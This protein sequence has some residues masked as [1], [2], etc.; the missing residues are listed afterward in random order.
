MRMAGFVT[1]ENLF[2]GKV[3]RIDIPGE[4]GKAFTQYFG[5]QAFYRLTPVSE[6]VARM[7]A[8]RNRTWPVYVYELQLAA[9]VTRDEQRADSGDDEGIG[10]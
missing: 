6:Q 10:F 9:P 7:F 1:E 8:E 5:G 2:G 4:E 3:G